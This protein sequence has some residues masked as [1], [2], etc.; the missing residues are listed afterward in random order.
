MNNLN[1]LFYDYKY[2]NMQLVCFVLCF[3]VY[4]AKS[5]CLGELGREFFLIKL[6][7]PVE[8]EGMVPR[9]HRAVHF[10]ALKA[11]IQNN[12]YNTNNYVST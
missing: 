1:I 12:S 2:M 3:K 11:A 5:K 9:L 10:Q 8:T 7:S 4:F 6:D